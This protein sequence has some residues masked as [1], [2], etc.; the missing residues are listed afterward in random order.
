MDILTHSADGILTI[1]FNRPDKKNAITTAMYQAMADAL[2]AADAD[3]AIRV[4][5]FAGGPQVFTAGNDIE[6]FLRHPPDAVDHPAL[7][8]LSQL[9]RA[10]KPLLAAVRGAAVGIGTT[11]LLH[12]ELVYAAEDARFSLPFTQ[13]GLCPE[14]ASS[15][16]LPRVAGYQRAAEKLLLGEPFSAQDAR[17]MGLV[18][19]VLPNSE[20]Q[21]FAQQQAAKLAALPPNAIRLT[22]Q[23]LKSSQATAVDAKMAEEFRHFGVLLVSDEA[24]E[25]FTAFLERR[26]PDFSRCGG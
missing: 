16:L 24:R 19:Q 6:D 26:K 10:G 5:L 13:L 9:S 4:I 2:R 23:L 14:A 3:P 18:N 12:C 21:A 11:L 1:T 17:E 20:V 15:Y 25:A 8:F 22:K 7:L